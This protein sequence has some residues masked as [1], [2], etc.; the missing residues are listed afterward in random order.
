MKNIAQIQLKCVGCRSCEQSCPKECITMIENNEGFLYPKIDEKMCIECQKC[1]NVCPVKRKELHRNESKSIFA[2]K[3]KNE[4]D[5]MCSASGGIA[6]SIT[7]TI[8]KES[9]VVFGAAY[10]KNLEV[11]HIEITEDKERHRLQSSKYVQSDV[12]NSF[13]KVKAR[14]VE[15]KKVLFTGTPCQISALYSYLGGDKEGL[16][17]IDLICHGV[18]SPKLFKKYIDYQEKKLGEKIIEYNFRSKDKRGWG[19]QYILKTKTKTKTKTLILDK[20]GKHFMLG[21]C[22]RECCYEC[23]YANVRRVGDITVGD[24]WGIAKTHP[25]FN[26]PLGVS[27]ILI[28]TEKGRELFEKTKELGSFEKATLNEALIKQTNLIRP[29][30]RPKQRNEFYINFSDENFIKNLSIG[31]QLKERVKLL[32]PKKIINILKSL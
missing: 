19:T 12:N 5:I 15:G 9:G 29:T 20:Y 6:D 22:Y 32:I 2:W 1:I 11:R 18:P 26:S 28:N 27:T 23:E 7:K 30:K 25:K 10:D 31:L 16:Y 14:L 13:T 4:K 17:T 21:D 24:F 8:L 3:N